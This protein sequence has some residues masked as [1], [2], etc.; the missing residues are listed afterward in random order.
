[1]FSDDFFD[2]FPSTDEP[3]A[4]FGGPAAGLI[5][6]STEAIVSPDETSGSAALNKWEPADWLLSTMMA[7]NNTNNG[8]EEEVRNNGSTSSSIASSDD[9]PTMTGFSSPVGFEEGGASSSSSGD[10]LNVTTTQLWTT[11]HAFASFAGATLADTLGAVGSATDQHVGFAQVQQGA[12]FLWANKSSSP[13]EYT[14]AELLDM[15]PAALDD[16]EDVMEIDVST[17]NKRPRLS[18]KSE[19]SPGASSVVN[20]DFSDIVTP[21]LVLLSNNLSNVGAAGLG[22]SDVALAGHHESV[23]NPIWHWPSGSPGPSVSL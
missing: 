1:M 4:A 9:C 8:G 10:V 3:E 13:G 17:S 11:P 5:F 16:D 21:D 19:T 18:L 7:A 15:L 14:T 12:T 22:A 2:L 6:G 20:D 23:V